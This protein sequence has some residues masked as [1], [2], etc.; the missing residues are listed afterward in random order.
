[1]FS[2]A[3]TPDPDRYH[4]DEIDATGRTVHHLD[5]RSTPDAAA[6]RVEQLRTQEPGRFAGH[7]LIVIDSHRRQ[8]AA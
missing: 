5:T 2:L 7:D 1:M 6:E 8:R 4:V 3:R